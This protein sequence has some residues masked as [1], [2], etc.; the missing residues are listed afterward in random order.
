MKSIAALVT[1]PN[2]EIDVI[3]SSCCPGACRSDL[4]RELKGSGIATAIGLMI[5]DLLFSK[6][7]EESGKVYVSAAA[8]GYE[9]HGGWY[10]TTS[11]TR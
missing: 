1:R 9:A 10:K 3:V 7:T 5:F 11:L 4:I 2:G 6:T 8:L